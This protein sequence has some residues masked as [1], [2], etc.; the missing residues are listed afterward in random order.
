MGFDVVELR[1]AIDEHEAA[2]IATTSLETAQK[3]CFRVPFC[4]QIL[5]DRTKGVPVA[6]VRHTRGPK[7]RSSTVGR[8]RSDSRSAQVHVEA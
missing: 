3:S 4:E 5:E 7:R 8:R 2:A 6:R 1:V